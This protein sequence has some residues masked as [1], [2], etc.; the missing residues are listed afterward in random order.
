MKTCPVV[1]SHSTTRI[2]KSVA[3]KLHPKRFPEMSGRMTAVVAFL[4]DEQVIRPAIVEIVVTSDGF[5]L[6]GVDDD[7]GTNHFVGTYADLVRNW[8]ALLA[9]AGLTRDERIAVEALFASRII[10]F[11][12]TNA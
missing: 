11:G 1:Q 3:E 2:L 5:V 10:Y 6:A 4:I 9:V 12:R 8:I 7:V